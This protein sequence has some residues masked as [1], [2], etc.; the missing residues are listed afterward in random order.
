VIGYGNTPAEQITAAVNTLAEC[1]REVAGA[2]RRG[3]LGAG[4]KV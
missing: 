1:V 3:R 4:V 2:V